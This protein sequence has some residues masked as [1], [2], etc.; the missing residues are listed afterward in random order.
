MRRRRRAATVEH[1]DQPAHLQ[2]TRTRDVYETDLSERVTCVSQ[3]VVLQGGNTTTLLIADANGM[4]GLKLS[5][6]VFQ[7][8]GE[9]SE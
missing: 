4:Q 5:G 9:C 1:H 8:N 7:L 3:C 2:C 6:A